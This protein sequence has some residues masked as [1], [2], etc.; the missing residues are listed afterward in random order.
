MARECFSGFG[1]AFGARGVPGHLLAAV[2]RDDGSGIAVQRVQP[3]GFPPVIH[4]A[5][6]REFVLACGWIHMRSSFWMSITQGIADVQGISIYAR[7][8]D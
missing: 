3:D 7:R 2:A 1:A 4:R 6:N 8:G 5:V